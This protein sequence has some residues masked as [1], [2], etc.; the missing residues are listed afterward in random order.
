[1]IL[2]L[3]GTSHLQFDRLLIAIDDIAKN[4]KEH[5]LVQKGYS[6][7]VGKNYEAFNF[8][9][10]KKIIELIKKS[11]IVISQGGFG[12][13]YDAIKNANRV[14]AVAREVEFYETDAEQH[15]LVNY[16]RDLGLI[17][18]CE[19]LTTLSGMLGDSGDL[20]YK[21]TANDS[22]LSSIPYVYELLSRYLEAEK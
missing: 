9:S 17:E 11:R 2:V 8:C 22:D 4:N 14:I 3:L 7:Y 1:M 6:L 5:I 10:R 15:S 12:S 16:Y 20:G 21:L 13:M 18:K 19:N